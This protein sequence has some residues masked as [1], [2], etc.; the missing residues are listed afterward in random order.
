MRSVSSDTFTT[1][2]MSFFVPTRQREEERRRRKPCTRAAR[3]SAAATMPRGR[4]PR[5]IQSRCMRLVR[6]SAVSETACVRERGNDYGKLVA[7]LHLRGE[8]VDVERGVDGLHF[9]TRSEAGRGSSLELR[10]QFH[11]DGAETP[12]GGKRETKRVHV[13]LEQICEVDQHRGVLVEAAGD[14]QTRGTDMGGATSLPIID[15]S[16]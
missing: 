12:S 10:V 1:E 16:E 7:E 4:R 14:V 13:C 8:A 11:V 15:D 9:Q 5:T 2:R 6:R 3:S